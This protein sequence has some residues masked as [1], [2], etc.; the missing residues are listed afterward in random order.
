MNISGDVMKNLLR[1]ILVIVIIAIVMVL[2]IYSGIYNISTTDPH[3]KFTRWIIS[4]MTDNSIKHHAGEITEPPNLTDSSLI[5]TGFMHYREMCSGCHGAPGIARNEVAEGLYPKPPKLLKSA[6]EWK[7]AE[8]FWIIKNGI[9]MTGMPGFG[10][11]H[12]DDKIWA[13][14]GFMGKLPDMSPEQYKAMDNKFKKEMD[15]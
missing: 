5:K 2:F 12:P 13:I 7:P 4:K 10:I 6:K 8:L 14:V 3:Y 1:G 15:E 11:S 9:K